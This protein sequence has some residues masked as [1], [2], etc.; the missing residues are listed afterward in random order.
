MFF[1]EPFKWNYTLQCL[2]FSYYFY[3]LKHFDGY[4][5]WYLFDIVPKFK[6]YQT[7]YRIYVSYFLIYNTQGINLNKKSPQNAVSKLHSF[8]NLHNVTSLLHI[9]LW[10]AGITNIT[11]CS[12]IRLHSWNVFY[13]IR[14]NINYVKNN[15][16]TFLNNCKKL[17]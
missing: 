5:K 15:M 16:T 13:L 7:Y 8:L 14:K 9:S 1:F 6:L 3:L 11:N 12:I 10:L 17:Y 4:S 2:H